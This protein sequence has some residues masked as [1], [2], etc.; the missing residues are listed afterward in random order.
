[1]G[2]R[3][4]ARHALDRRSEEKMTTSPPVRRMAVLPLGILL[5]A[6]LAQAAF[7][8]PP[9]LLGQKLYQSQM[10]VE[11]P[12][13]APV[14]FEKSTFCRSYQC[15]GTNA[16]GDVKTGSL[17]WM[18]LSVGADSVMAL[19]KHYQGEFY[20]EITLQ[21]ENNVVLFADLV[22]SVDPEAPL[23][24]ARFNQIGN[25]SRLV[26]GAPVSGQ[27]ISACYVKLLTQVRCTVGTGVIKVVGSVTRKF[28]AELRTSDDGEGYTSVNYGIGFID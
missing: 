13:P 5:V 27:K 20:P 7:T 4:E 8:L 16:I 19:K 1:M 15:V 10:T 25:F 6:G 26:L 3:R 21:Y 9:R 22:V 14:A 28:T 23:S 12:I 24:T 17:S 18:V 2:C 11:G